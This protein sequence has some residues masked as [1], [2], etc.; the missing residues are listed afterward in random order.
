[1]RYLSDEEDKKA[2]EYLF[3]CVQLAQHATCQRSRCGSLIVQNDQI[4]GSGYN[5][6]PQGLESQRRCSCAKENYHKKVT[7]KTCCIHAEQRAIMDTLQHNADQIV[8]SRLYFVRLD[9]DGEITFAGKPYCTICSKMALDVGVAEF[10]LRHKE[11]IAVYPTDE[12][13][14]ISFSYT[15]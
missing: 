3:E 10:V 12:Y 14:Q 6:P 11:G 13:N 2:R 7:D 1:M 8:W 15:E 9:D 5:T 4:I